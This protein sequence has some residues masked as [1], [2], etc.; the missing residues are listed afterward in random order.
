MDNRPIPQQLVGLFVGVAGLLLAILLGS[1]I[2]TGNYTPLLFGLAMVAVVSLALF[3]GPFFWIITIASSFLGGTFPILGGSF[4]PFQVLMAIGVAKFVVEDI[5]LRRRRFNFGNRL[6]LLLIG[7]FMAIITVHGI[8]DRFGMRF[9]G[10]SIWGGA[11]YVN[12]Y[13]G[14]AAFFVTQS[15]SM[16]PRL[17]AK[18]PY[19]ILAVTGFDV[20]IAVITTIFP[21]LIYKIYPFYSAVSTSAI[22]EILTGNAVDTARLGPFG[23]FGLALITLILASVSLR[24]IFVPPFF[25][26]FV[27]LFIGSLGVLLSSYRSNVFY[28]MAVVFIAGVRDLKF[29]ILIF[30]PLLAAVLFGLSVLNSEFVPL[31][32]QMQR[33]L[34]FL[35]GKWDVE[36]QNDAL[37]SNEFRKEIW[38][39]WKREFFP[40]HPW[41]GRGFGFRTEQ[42]APSTYHPGKAFDYH[43]MVEVGNIHNGFLSCIDTLGIIGTLFFVLWN[44]RLLA[45]TF[46]ISFRNTTPE[47]T[48]LRFLALFLGCS[49][50]GYWLSA[51]NL[52]SFLPREFALAGVFL[53]LRAEGRRAAGPV[54][55]PPPAQAL[56]L[57]QRIAIA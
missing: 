24:R 19:V 15:I 28:T 17:W 40:L 30:L 23:N 51:P 7:T 26:R 5:V 1:K 42:A 4:T 20:I 54:V 11:N 16:K 32:K 21:S 36:M 47:E 49:I 27:G 10:S 34:A 8:H 53:Q 57:P 52:G 14:L 43:Q 13:L 44:M 45:R 33:T 41:L 25:F 48:G 9:L 31:P 3:S 2:G 18:L 46:Q 35:P 39:T 50:L 12:V 38:T 55:S 29:R 37:A 22:Q 56:P 6:D